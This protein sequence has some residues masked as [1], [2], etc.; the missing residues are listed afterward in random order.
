[1]ITA[2]FPEVVNECLVVWAITDIIGIVLGIM[3]TVYFAVDNYNKFSIEKKMNF[4]E[5]NHYFEENVISPYRK[6]F[7]LNQGLRYYNTHFRKS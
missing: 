2:M 5:R 4:A 3:V 7:S 6:W 1:M